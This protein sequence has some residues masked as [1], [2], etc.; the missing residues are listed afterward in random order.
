MEGLRAFMT[1]HN[2]SKAV[3]DYYDLTHT[4][5]ET[6]N[7]FNRYKKEGMAEEAKGMLDDEEKKRLIAAAPALR[8]V[9]ENMA[10][11]RA[12]I[13]ML[14]ENQKIDPDTRRDEINRLQ[15]MVDRMAKQGL[16]LAEQL[17]IR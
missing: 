13:N 8:R 16:Q 14:R 12:N 5:Q 3:A 7:E 11:V 1:N 9:Q 10:K 2:A 17:K 6:V 15:A 4:A